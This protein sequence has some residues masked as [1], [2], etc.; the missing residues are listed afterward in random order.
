MSSA[1]DRRAL[2]EAIQA[3]VKT[4]HPTTTH[5]E[6]ICQALQRVATQD[7]GIPI[8]VVMQADCSSERANP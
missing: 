3:L 7:Y 6:A 2:A 8:R 4:N 5:Y 1:T